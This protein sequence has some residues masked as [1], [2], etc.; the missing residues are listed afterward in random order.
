VAK[1]LQ[2]A[3]TKDNNP[4]LTDMT[5]YGVIKEIWMLD[6]FS[7]QIPVFK[8][9]WVDSKHSVKIDELG[10]TSVELD[11]IGHKSDSFIL[12][13]Q[14]K[15]VF[16]VPDQLNDKWSIVLSTPQRNY[17][18]EEND[19]EVI[20]CYGGDETSKKVPDIESYDMIDESP[21]NYAREDCEGTWIEKFQGEEQ[22]QT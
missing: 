10:F 20:D 9:D 19:D 8:C 14:A 4:V 7:F 17:Y 12:A 18:D 15:Q 13:S 6:Y 11:R 1:T 21:S 16:Y 3:S 5:F 2:V 22:A